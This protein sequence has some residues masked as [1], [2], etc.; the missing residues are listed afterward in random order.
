M[1]IAVDVAQTCVER[2]G[3]AWHAHSLAEELE[4]SLPK[5]DLI[6]YHHFG[7]WINNNTERGT[8]LESANMPFLGM[9]PNEAKSI[10]K[11]IESGTTELPGNPDI[12][13]SN[14]FMGPKLNGTKLVYTIHDLTFWTHPEF[15]TELNRAICQSNL[16]RALGNADAFIFVSKQSRLDFERITRGWIKKSEKPYETIAP[17]STDIRTTKATDPKIRFSDASAPWLHLGSLEPR[18]GIEDLLEAYTE[19]Y[20]KSTRK[21]PLLLIGGQGWL[22]SKLIQKIESLTKTMPVLYKG[23]CDQTTRNRALGKAFGLL[24]SSKYEGYGLP[25]DEAA[26][27]GLPFIS[28][29]VPS[30]EKFFGLIPNLSKLRFAKDANSML[31]LE[32]D[33]ELYASISV[34]LIQISKAFSN[35][36]KTKNLV[37]FYET[38]LGKPS[39]IF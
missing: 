13:H 3:C 37:T 31:E 20:K 21:R 29:P 32:N 34:R 22:S 11:D 2:G 28:T 39:K 36:A 10:W 24:C 17:F 33:W 4:K 18:K 27:S 6:L 9:S 5:G 38:I 23:Y 14:S 12:V 19:Y 35:E 15:N 7:D 16:L 26:N 1:R 8:V 25:I 30:T